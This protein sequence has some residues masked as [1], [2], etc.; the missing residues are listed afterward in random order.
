MFTKTLG[1]VLG[2]G[3]LLTSAFVSGF[4][5]VFRRVVRREGVDQ[6]DVQVRR[7]AEAV[8]RGK[9]GRSF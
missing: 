9:H 7:G 4:E 5:G 1:V 6:Q 3:S 8:Q 2:S